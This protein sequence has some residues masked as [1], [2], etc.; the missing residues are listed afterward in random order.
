LTKRK[1]AAAAEQGYRRLRRSADVSQEFEQVRRAE[2]GGS[3]A[4][5]MNKVSFFTK[6]KALFRRELWRPLLVGIGL[7]MA[8]QLSGVNVV[9][10]YSTSIFTSAG[11]G[12]Y[13]ALC[14]TMVGLVNVIFTIIVVPL[15]DRLGRRTL[16]LI[17]ETGCFV[18]FGT[19]AL[20]FILQHYAVTVFGIIS[21]ICVIGFVISF[22]IALGPIPWLIISEIFP[23]DVRPL[24][25]SIA[26]TVNWTCNFVILL[27]FESM[28]NALKQYTFL[29]YTAIILLSIVFT[30]F[31]VMETKGKD[32]QEI[33]GIS[34]AVN[35]DESK[36]LLL[37][38]D[39]SS[40]E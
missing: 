29:P 16:L 39:Q 24:A 28:S 17:G 15:M 10:A 38:Q 5:D 36:G 6:V 9:F 8:Q 27:T 37:A 25:V 22:A 21:V 26:V 32:I 30:V 12:N 40:E 13:A 35:T 23:S 4:Y 34:S 3:G 20:C 14:T 1:D 31:L 2:L 18:F 7:Q 19:L 33:I 11:L